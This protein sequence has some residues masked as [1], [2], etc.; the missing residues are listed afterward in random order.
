MTD[1]TSSA[2]LS[3][4]LGQSGL[5]SALNW[6]N[7]A[8]LLI[9]EKNLARFYDAVVRPPYE[10]AGP[11]TIKI[12]KGQ[13]SEIV[14]KFGAK[15]K[16]GLPDWIS[17][18]FSAGVEVSAEGQ[19]TTGSNNGEDV[20]VTLAP[21]ES[22]QRQLVQL[23][24]FYL[25]N[26]PDRLLAGSTADVLRWHETGLHGGAPRALAFVDLPPKTRMIPMA[27]EF[28]TG[29]VATFFDK[30]NAETGEKPPK[31]S[32]DDKC[33]YWG[34]YSKNF[35]PKQ[36]TEVIEGGASDGGGRIQWIDF[37]VPLNDKVDTAHLHMEPAGNYYTG[38]LAYRLVRRA[39][40][41]GLRIVGTLM[42]G[43]DFNVLA[44]YE[45]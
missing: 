35:D 2:P 30:L 38:S 9:D 6:L 33:A 19:G 44:V 41:H 42:D 32:S 36:S 23:A 4:G 26:H 37:R 20:T 34:W 13:K 3:T 1:L 22:P 11:R 43:P 25:L 24:A 28:T 45:K 31:F 7:D 10:E 40:G 18:L 17:A 27:A 5:P 14:G 8:P 15:G 12:S 21:I 39:H 16:I 29:K